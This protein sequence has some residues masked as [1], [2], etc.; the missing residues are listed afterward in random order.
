MKRLLFAINV[1]WYFNLHWKE[2]VLSN[3]TKGY[4]VHLCLAKTDATFHCENCENKFVTINRSSIGILS[5]IKSLLSLFKI[6]RDVKP[7]LIHSVTVKPN[8]FYGF[9][10]R[11]F[12][13]PIVI[14][15]P[16]LGTV[17]SSSG[18]K[19]ALLRQLII[20]LYKCAGKN[21][22]S[23]FVFENSADMQ[24]FINCGI[25][26]KQSCSLVSGA[27]VDI[28]SFRYTPERDFARSPLR[29][30]FAGRLLYGKGLEDLINAVQKLR[31]KGKNVRLDVAGIIDS[32]SRE[33]ISLSQIEEWSKLDEINW[34]GQVE[35]M[36]GLLNEVHIVALPT[37]YGEGLPRILLEASACGRP[38]ITTDIPGCRDFVE[39]GVNG[40]LVTPGVIDQLVFAIE[41]LES[42]EVRKK[43]GRAGRRKV[44]RDYTSKKVIQYYS[45]IYSNL[46]TGV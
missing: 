30:L 32:D 23:F 34:L 42:V 18:W 22:K 21:D 17:F 38:V 25:C 8:L 10:A 11:I 44:E 39:N 12:S 35:D 9:F 37:R 19:Y 29:V 45:N 2:R 40:I 41:S 27:G 24:Q 28:H 1:D 5:N 33:A 4:E 31:A 6:F 7:D 13:I 20:F 26:D 15:I 46:M 3:M 16:G 36:A 14:T 43:M